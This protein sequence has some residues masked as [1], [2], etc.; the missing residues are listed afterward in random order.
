MGFRVEGIVCKEIYIKKIPIELGFFGAHCR[1][2]TYGL[3]GVN[4]LLYR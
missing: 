3:P 2:R 4:G 1:I